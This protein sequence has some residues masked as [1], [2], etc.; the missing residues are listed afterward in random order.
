[1]RTV[2]YTFDIDVNVTRRC[3]DEP[4]FPLE[5]IHLKD[6]LL[7]LNQHPELTSGNG[8]YEI[9]ADGIDEGISRFDKPSKKALSFECDELLRL[10]HS[11][12]GDLNVV[13]LLECPHITIIIT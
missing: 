8:E 12:C 1:M 2:N 4:F 11:G 10:N 7:W 6:F 3:Y 13:L 5:T 9:D